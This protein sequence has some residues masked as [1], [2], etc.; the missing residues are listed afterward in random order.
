MPFLLKEENVGDPHTN[1]AGYG[2]MSQYTIP[3]LNNKEATIFPVTL[4]SYI[5]GIYINGVISCE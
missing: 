3:C 5:L 1:R 2:P 4:W